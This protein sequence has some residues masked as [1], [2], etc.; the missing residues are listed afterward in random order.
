MENSNFTWITLFCFF[1]NPCNLAWFICYLWNL[2]YDY[3]KMSYYNG[4]GN[5]MCF[6]TWKYK[7]IMNN[8]TP[9]LTCCVLT[10]KFFWL[11]R[12]FIVFPLPRWKIY[13]QVIFL[14]IGWWLVCI[15]I[16]I[17]PRSAIRPLPHSSLIIV[18]SANPWSCSYLEEWHNELVSFLIWNRCEVSILSFFLTCSPCFSPFLLSIFE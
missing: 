12:A 5:E 8:R 2:A 15:P 3:E 1:S 6:D 13:S 16:L 14:S 17:L 9:S 18:I 10:Y 11:W 7:S 4:I